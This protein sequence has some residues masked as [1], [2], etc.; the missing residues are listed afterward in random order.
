MPSD[1]DELAELK[2][3]VKEQ[4]DLIAALYA[5]VNLGDIRPASAL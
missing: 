1:Q 2:R 5:H 4:G 3:Q